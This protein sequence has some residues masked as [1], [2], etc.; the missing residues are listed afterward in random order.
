MGN[1]QQGISVQFF[2]SRMTVA[3]GVHVLLQFGMKEKT[4]GL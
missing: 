4:N 3:Q 1:L 2:Y